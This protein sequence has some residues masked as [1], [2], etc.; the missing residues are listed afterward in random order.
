MTALLLMQGCGS[1]GRGKKQ[2]LQGRT[3]PHTCSTPHTSCVQAAQ[4]GESFPS[5]WRQQQAPLNAP[6]IE[7]GKGLYSDLSPAAL[8]LPNIPET[9]GSWRAAGA[10]RA[11]HCGSAPVHATCGD[12]WPGGGCYLHPRLPGSESR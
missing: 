4:A 10:P 1:G 3:D 11:S 9:A 2:A 7:A 5:E 8:P 6:P 12:A